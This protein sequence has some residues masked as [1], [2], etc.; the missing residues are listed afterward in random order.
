MTSCRKILHYV[1]YVLH[2]LIS[3]FVIEVLG[4]R[5]P[6]ESVD[7]ISYT[8]K[9]LTTEIDMGVMFEGLDPGHKHSLVS[10]VSFHLL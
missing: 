4:W 2:L 1:I 7:N 3:G 6:L 5:T 8:L 10:M 9:A